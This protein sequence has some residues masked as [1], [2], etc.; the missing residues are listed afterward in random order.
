M[1]RILLPGLE[2]GVKVVYLTCHIA[3]PRPSLVQ[4]LPLS[5]RREQNSI[6]LTARIDLG[7]EISLAEVLFREDQDK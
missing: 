4:T 6:A 7:Q 5:S 3:A 2:N 1:A